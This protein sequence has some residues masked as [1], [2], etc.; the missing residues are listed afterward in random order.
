MSGPTLHYVTEADLVDRIGQQAVLD[1]LDFDRDGVAD[2]S[3]VLRLLLDAVSYVE[4]FLHRYSLDVLRAMNPPPNEVVRLVLDRAEAELYCKHPEFARFDGYKAKE[5][6]DKELEKLALGGRR[7]DVVGPP[8]P[9]TNEGG[10]VGSND[11]RDG[12]RPKPRVFDKL[13]DF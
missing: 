11:A 6:C 10:T 12:F 9:A 4:S 1:M 2:P 8:E 13:G 7:L 3:K 5:R